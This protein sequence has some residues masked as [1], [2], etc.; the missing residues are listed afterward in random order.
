MTARAKRLSKIKRDILP[1]IIPLQAE[2]FRTALIC[3]DIALL[4]DVTD[5]GVTLDAAEFS[6][7][8]AAIRTA[9]PVTAACFGR[10]LAGEFRTE[11]G[12]KAWAALARMEDA[13]PFVSTNV[14]GSQVISHERLEKEVE[15][16]LTKYAKPQRQNSKGSRKTP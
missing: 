8:C 11:S 6:R 1:D 3:D 12:R 16:I 15:R 9:Y 5:W 4:N 7:F 14:N 13:A 2:R 10:W